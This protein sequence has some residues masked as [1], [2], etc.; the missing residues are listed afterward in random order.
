MHSLLV[1]RH[2]NS[3]CELELLSAAG[4]KLIFNHSN[5]SLLCLLSVVIEI[6]WL[7][8]VFVF[9]R[10]YLFSILFMLFILFYAVLRHPYYCRFESVSI[11]LNIYFVLFLVCGAFLITFGL[12]SFVGNRD[13]IY[14][15]CAVVDIYLLWCLS[16]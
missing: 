13:F 4:S 9:W 5:G 1:R 7:K 3:F 15:R 14:L 10:N 11:L 12:D 8:L 2:R 16:I 6:C